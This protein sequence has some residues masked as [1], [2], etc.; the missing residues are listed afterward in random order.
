MET[1]ITARLR[2]QLGTAKNAAEMFR[3]FSRFNALFVRP[4]I[5]G[6]IREYQTQ[7]IQRVKD[8]IE[9]LHEKFKIQYPQSKAYKMSG[10]RD[11]PPVA[12]S[13]I[14]ARQ[15]DRQLSAYMRRVE[16]VLG[17]GWE[18]H[19]EGQKLKADGDSFRMKLNTQEIF[20]DWARKVQH[21]NLGVSGRIFAIDNQRTRLGRGNLKLRVNFLPEII[22][23]SKEVRNLKNL[24]FRVPLAIVN[25]AHQANQLYPFAISLIESVRTYER[26]LEKLDQRP[27][28]TLLVAGLHKEVQNVVAEGIGLV[29]E[30]YKLDPYVQRLAE[31]VVNFQEKVDD[32]IIVDEEIDIDVRSLETCAYSANI[33]KETL[34]KIQKAVDDLSL[35][36]YSNLHAWVGKLDEAVE[37]KLGLRLQA[38]IEAWTNCLLGTHHDNEED[39]D[40]MDT[41]ASKFLF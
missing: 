29:W 7:L 19:V 6:A 9:A 1:R 25:K 17:R 22:Q 37:E 39:Q 34:G 2:D 26:S 30:S 27:K 3:I 40:D 8:D 16:D 12:G 41:H 23:L 13:I 15:I 21:R 11:L 38:G 28:I 31:L 33:F 14:W 18:N 24:G 32:L 20:D 4:H 36:Q 35:R 10:V 5:R